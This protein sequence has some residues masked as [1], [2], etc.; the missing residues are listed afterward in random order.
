MNAWKTLFRS[1]ATQETGSLPPQLL[2]H[3]PTLAS[4]G[5]AWLLQKRRDCQFLLAVS[6]SAALENLSSSLA[7][8][9]ELLEDPR[10]VVPIPEVSLGRRQ[11]VPENE[12]CRSASLQEILSGRPAIFLATAQTLLS[13]TLSPRAFAKRTFTLKLHQN[14][15]PEELARQLTALDYDSEYQVTSPGEFARRG[16]ILDI[17]SP[18]YA[19]P[20]RLEFFGDEIDSMRFFSASTQCSLEKLDSFQVTPRGSAILEC[21]EGQE[22]ARVLQY[23]SPETTPM[24]LVLP[25]AIEDH[26]ACFSEDSGELSDWQQAVSQFRHL[27]RMEVPPLLEEGRRAC[28]GR[29]EL[30]VLPL[31]EQWF[32]TVDREDAANPEN[33]IALWHW[34]QLKAS[35]ARWR[36]E[37]MQI[38]ACCNGAG[39]LD[40][41]KELL[42]QDPETRDFPLV[43]EHRELPQGFFFPTQ[44]LVLL[45]DQELFGRAPV[46]RK[47]RHV[48]Y[49]YEA[50]GAPEILELEKGALAVHLNH[51]ICRFHGIHFIESAGEKLEAI[52]L[53]FADEA[54]LY[55]HMDQAGLVSRYVG[56]GKTTPPLSHLGASLWARKKEAAENAA[57][58]LAAELLRL[59]AMRASSDGSQFHAMPE[60]ERS[61]AASFPYDLT[62]DQEDAIQACFQDMEAPKPMDRLLCGDVGYGKT[63][64]ALRV[65]FRAVMNGKQVALLVPTTILA[66]QHFQTFQARFREFPV[67]VEMLSRLRPA[68][69][70]NAIIRDLNE[71]KVDIIIGTHRLLSQDIRIPKLGLLII[72][73]EQRFGVKHKQKLKAMRASLDIL[74]M[75]ATPI[76]RTLYMSLSGLRNLS[77]IMTAPTNRLSVR[78]VVANYDKL[79]IQEAI[80]HELERGGQ[81][82][83]LHNRVRTIEAVRDVLQHLVPQ[84]TFAV[85]HG[86]M[87]PEELEQVMTR[88]VQ[89]EVDVLVSTTI[90]ES[91]IDIPNA[92]TIIV[93]RADCFGL[94]ELYQL[95][96]RVGRNFQQAYAYMLLPP[97]GELPS[98]ARERMAAIR[99]FTHLGA[100][101]RLAMKDMEIRGAGNLLGQEQSGHIAAV[102]FELYCQLLKDCVAKL[103]KLPCVLRQR[104]EVNLDML[105]NSVTPVPHK[106]QASIPREYV[107]DESM[108]L[109]LYRKF[110]TLLTPEEVEEFGKELQDRFGALPRSVKNLL[111]QYRIETLARQKGLERLTVKSGRVVAATAK[112]IYRLHGQVP[113]LLSSNPEKQ[114]AELEELLRAMPSSTADTVAAVRPRPPRR[115]PL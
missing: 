47:H 112:E 81:V 93:D 39:E 88:F 13:R 110:Q 113:V 12:A 21:Q 59:E 89:G 95:R 45:S 92:N 104:L 20:V 52:E 103:Q 57:W 100:G 23:F 7:G 49:H 79:L 91:G 58:D 35:L 107:S 56:G 76:P 65:A 111:A 55:V 17:F 102:G 82:Y 9:L 11:W 99:R 50:A 94:S 114:L 31:E 10:P 70:Q 24:A 68:A 63:E 73:E 75:T 101:F 61:F 84:A 15:P 26:L 32:A 4:V 42:E 19:D 37:K 2:L 80:L 115:H 60:W 105:C 36:K 14:I 53:E 54:R 97:M 51:G 28:L 83:Y 90:I 46:T 85:G 44:K 25:D 5:A 86:R 98:N 78:T 29:P 40:R 64:V 33:G 18:L 30:D 96:G 106:A 72:D 43:L 1:W 109:S 108:R 77:T 66:Q 38:V 16:G 27:V 87:E 62:P 71:G 48:D 8:F 34:N 67:R 3:E 22:E 74:T 69:A 41:L 6:D